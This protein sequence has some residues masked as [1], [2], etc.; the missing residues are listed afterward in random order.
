MRGLAALLVLGIAAPVVNVAGQRVSD[1][2]TLLATYDAANYDSVTINAEAIRDLGEFLRDLDRSASA[3]IRTAGDARSRD[4]R[5]LVAASFALE[6]A[7]ANR[8]RWH[9]ARHLVEWGC[10]L[11][12]SA[13][14]DPGGGAT[15]PTPSDGYRLWQLAS[16]A[17]IESRFDHI[18]LMG[19]PPVLPHDPDTGRGRARNHLAH[20]IEYLPHESRLFLAFATAAEFASWGSDSPQPIWVDADRIEREEPLAP[21]VRTDPATARALLRRQSGLIYVAAAKS[22]TLWELADIL[23]GERPVPPAYARLAGAPSIQAELHVRLGNT[24]LRLARAD[25]ALPPL[26][27]ALTQTQEP[28][29]LYLANYLR[30]R[31]FEMLQRTADAETAYRDALVAMPRA[32]SASISLAALLFADGRRKEAATYAAESVRGELPLDPWRMYQAG[33]GRHWPSLI[34]LLRQEIR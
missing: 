24:Y 22:D 6:V 28:F 7:S 5:R 21:G 33:S 32:Q 4:R 2:G 18:F 31:A 3:W 9:D 10:T 15:P 12:R 1:A 25:L 17:L 13:L 8:D 30:G 14:R 34:R 19:V 23:R 26:E 29:L 27:Q 11:Q 20:A 16:I